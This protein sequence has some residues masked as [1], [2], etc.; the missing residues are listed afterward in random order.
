ME[1]NNYQL[2]I[3]TSTADK[4]VVVSGAGAGKTSC[5]IARFKHLLDQ[6]VDPSKMVLITFTNAAAEEIYERVGH[7]TGAFIGT[8]HAYAN[9]LLLS[10]GKDTSDILNEEKFD[11]LFERIKNRPYCVKEVE[12]LLL[13]EGQDSTELQFEFLFDVIKP[14]N[15]MIF[16]DWRQSIYRWSGA[17]PDYIIELTQRS[18]VTTYYLRANYRN[19]I[20]ILDFAKAIIR[21]NGYI[22][23]DNTFPTRDEDGAVYE[24]E[25]DPFSIAATIKQYD[26]Y[27]DWFVLTRT[28]DQLDDI[29]SYLR[30]HNI[31]CDSFKRA[32]LDN[33][34]LNKKMKE[35]TVKVLT[36]HTAKGL[37]SKNV[38]VIGARFYNI[39]EKCIS[40][41]AATRA[42]DLL[43]WTRMP[44]RRKKNYGTDNW[45]T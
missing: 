40:Y 24:I 26:T 15:W 25:Y 13:D 28:N 19:A 32:E 22:Y 31:P 38:V 35:N 12:H 1:L 27:G 21:T 29:L 33:K 39:E 34:T 8:I 4:A 5:L 14:K 37:E 16:S 45:E 17:Y 2:E 43:L 11:E 7:P 20:N 23:V 9:Y 3:A 10:K 42:K 18:D 44:S 41:V 36:I 30:R 6:G